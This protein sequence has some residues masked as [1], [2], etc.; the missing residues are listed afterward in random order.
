MY[1][2]IVIDTQNF[3]NQTGVRTFESGIFKKK[4]RGHHQGASFRWR[5]CMTTCA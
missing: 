3:T 5:I 1:A 2:G 4:R